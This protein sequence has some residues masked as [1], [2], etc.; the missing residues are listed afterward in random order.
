M[1]TFEKL[2]D[3]TLT[4]ADNKTT[5]ALTYTIQTTDDEGN[6]TEEQKI[7]YYKCTGGSS[8]TTETTISTTIDS[9]SGILG[10]INRYVYAGY[11]VNPYS[12]GT[13]DENN[14][15]VE[16]DN[17]IKLLYDAAK[18]IA[19][20]T[21]P[22]DGNYIEFSPTYFYYNDGYVVDNNKVYI[23]HNNIADDDMIDLYENQDDTSPVTIKFSEIQYKSTEGFYYETKT[24]KGGVEEVVTNWINDL[25]VNT[26]TGYRQVSEY[27][28]YKDGVIY[29]Q[30]SLYKIGTSNDEE[31][32]ENW[33]YRTYLYNKTSNKEEF[34]L[35]KYLTNETVGFYTLFKF[36][37]GYNSFNNTKKG[38]TYESDFKVKDEID[39]YYY[40]IPKNYSETFSG[41]PNGKT[42]YFVE[43]AKV[44][45]S[46]ADDEWG[47]VK[48]A[49]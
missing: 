11:F 26:I 40:L 45:I 38:D 10:T 19:S 42:T 48:T 9:E 3:G 13:L 2:K 49:D 6:V 5:F 41:D 30:S 18:Y 33:L 20:T 22:S 35:K 36:E 27:F 21:A 7:V 23:K 12:K 44:V 47:S 46:G 25:Y 32:N 4:S 37:E 31:L 43:S 29:M 17:D 15:W 28:R 24:D 16:L 34:V 39:K 14:K 1:A 8:E